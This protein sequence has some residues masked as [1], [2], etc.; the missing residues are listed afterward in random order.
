MSLTYEKPNDEKIEYGLNHIM[1]LIDDLCEVY[2]IDNQ[3]LDISYYKI[4][5]TLIRIDKRE[6]YFKYYHGIVMSEY[7][8]SA[9][10]AYWINK[11]R[12][13]HI[14][15]L[16]NTNCQILKEFDINEIFASY[17]IFSNL[18]GDNFAFLKTKDIVEKYKNELLYT[19]RFRDMSQD[20]FIFAL[21]PFYYEALRKSH[22]A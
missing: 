22:S 6:K 13:L 21:E 5:E 4:Y 17:V 1:Q 2:G 12:P 15:K 9:L 20:E 10:L 8:K 3:Y 16:Q 14:N 11:M 19:L 18:K 7:K